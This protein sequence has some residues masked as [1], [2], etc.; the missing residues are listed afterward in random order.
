[1]IPT[2]HKKKIP[3]THSYPLGA[4]AI[5]DALIDVPQRELPKINF[6]FYTGFAKDR[7][8][9]APYRV[10]SAS[11]SGSTF[12]SLA[13]WIVEV[14]AV[15]RPLKHV[16]PGKLIADALPKIREWLISTITRWSERAAT[17]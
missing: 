1:M 13:G 11:Y 14:H 5:S 16:I 4:K 17:I 6:D 12:L 2:G 15:P 9:G 10:L 3:S 7:V 8:P